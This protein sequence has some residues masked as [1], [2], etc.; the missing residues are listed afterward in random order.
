MI[1]ILILCTALIVSS[2]LWPE[3]TKSKLSKI[4]SFLLKAIKVIFW[5]VLYIGLAY[6][7]WTHLSSQESAL[8][9]IFNLITGGFVFIFAFHLNEEFVTP[10]RFKGFSS[11][12]EAVNFYLSNIPAYFNSLI[13]ITAIS[14]FLF[15]RGFISEQIEGKTRKIELFEWFNGVAVDFL[16][17]E[18]IFWWWCA[19]IMLVACLCLLVKCFMVLNANGVPPFKIFKLLNAPQK[20]KEE[21]DF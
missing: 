7:A 4:F 9:S 18:F 6:W 15:F 12:E 19:L 21:T 8:S 13:V 16:A 17:Q 11:V 20:Q 2:L 1:F 5:G 14:I 10:D 3:Q